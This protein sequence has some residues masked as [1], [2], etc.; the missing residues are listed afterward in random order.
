MNDNELQHVGVLGMKWGHRR[1]STDRMASKDAKRHMD[2]KMFY[3]ETAGTKRKLLKAELDKKKKTIP[4]YEE[5][6]NKHLANVDTAKSASK[7]VRTRVTTDTVTK[8]R[9]TLKKAVKA[10]GATTIIA[11]VAGVAYLKNKSRIDDFINQHGEEAKLAKGL[12]DL[13]KQMENMGPFG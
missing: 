3:G 5:A 7:A 12:F 10:V 9:K 11:A 6:F 13:A 8:G 2:A 4:G 1:N